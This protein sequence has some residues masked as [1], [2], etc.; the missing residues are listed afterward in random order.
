ME[1][2][3]RVC[4]GRTESP[5]VTTIAFETDR[6]TR[7]CYWC[8]MQYGDVCNFTSCLPTHHNFDDGVALVFVDSLN[9][10]NGWRVCPG[11]TGRTF[12]LVAACAIDLIARSCYRCLIQYGA[13]CNFT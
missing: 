6:F 10:W 4:S 9:E 5:F 3:C 7:H 11:R 2:G 8:S 1:R 13:V 12:V